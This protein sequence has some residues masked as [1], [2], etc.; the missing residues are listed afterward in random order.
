MRVFLECTCTYFHDFS[1]GVQR[2]VRNI[3]NASDEVGQSLGLECQPVVHIQDQGFYPVGSL[4][5]PNPRFENAKPSLSQRLRKNLIPRLRRLGLLDAAQSCLQAARTCVRQVKRLAPKTHSGPEPIQFQAGDVILLLDTSWR[6]DYW[7]DL[8]TAQEQGARVGFVVY[9]LIP[10]TSP[11]FIDRQSSKI[12]LKWWNGVSRTAD[13]VQCIS[14]TIC[15]EVEDWLQRH[16]ISGRKHP[17]ECGWFHLGFDLDGGTAN[18]TIREEFPSIFRGRM[19]SGTYLMVGS[20]NPRKNHALA[21]EAFDRLWNEGS[22]AKLVIIG[23]A[24]W[25]TEDFERRVNQHPELGR[26]LHWYV[27]VSDAEL[28]YAYRH[29][30]ALLTPSLAEGFNLPIIEALS[31]GCRVYASDLNVHRE[32]GGQWAEYFPTHSPE[33]LCERIRQDAV[34]FQNGTP[35]APFHWQDWQSSCRQLLTSLK[36]IVPTKTKAA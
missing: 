17:L 13:F 25:M 32:V 7:A 5:T 2:V 35:A 4:P 15:Q 27:N 30:T 28:D 22:Q 33:G 8:E 29:A 14:K 9:D 10:M 26:N 36:P 34:G 16:P 20:I 24:G 23:N 11:H 21:L 1:T 18:Q 3:I 12:F 19:H 31:R 6:L